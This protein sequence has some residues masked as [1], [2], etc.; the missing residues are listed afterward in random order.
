MKALSCETVKEIERLA[1]GYKEAPERLMEIL[2][3]IQKHTSNCFNREMMEIVSV[4]T[5]IPESKL[6]DH[7]TFY[8]MFST[9]ARGKY[10]IRMCKSAPCHVCG[11]REVA[12]AICSYLGILPGETTKD[13]VFTVEFC[14]CIGLCESSPSVMINDKPYSNLTPETIKGILAQYKKGVEA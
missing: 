1:A 3:E 14:E 5:G 2:L 10:L 7:T 8:A 12:D 13:G 9:E 4:A 6:F 11:A